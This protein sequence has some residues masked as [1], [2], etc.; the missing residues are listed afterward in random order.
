MNRAENSQFRKEGRELWV[1]I[2]TSLLLFSPSVVAYFF[3]RDYAGRGNSPL[4]APVAALMTLIVWLPAFYAS[5]DIP[6]RSKRF[7]DRCLLVFFIVLMVS[8]LRDP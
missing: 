6:D 1:I 8:V 4:N 3:C 2:K 5:R 7:F